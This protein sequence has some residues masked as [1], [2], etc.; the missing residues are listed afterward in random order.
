MKIL[1]LKDF[2]DYGIWGW[3]NILNHRCTIE[4]FLN[5]RISRTQ[6]IGLI[7]DLSA[8]VMIVNVGPEWYLK[9]YELEKKSFWLY[10]SQMQNNR[11]KIPKIR[12]INFSNYDIVLTS[13]PYIPEDIIKSCKTVFGYWDYINPPK[14]KQPCGGYDLQLNHLEGPDELISLPQMVFFH[15]PASPTIRA[16][17]DYI[18]KKEIYTDVRTLN[19]NPNFQISDLS[20]NNMQA[21]LP[22]RMKNGY[23]YYQL[24][25]ACKYLIYIRNGHGGSGQMAIELAALGSIIIGY[26][27]AKPFALI[28]HPFCKI[29][30]TCSE[31]KFPFGSNGYTDINYLKSIILKIE[32][33][34]LLYKEIIDYQNAVILKMFNNC[35]NI[36]EKAISIK[37]TTHGS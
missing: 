24:L 25:S 19:E 32:S 28:V 10:R 36:L 14:L 18:E 13:N 26:H 11:P 37:G 3:K 8:D 7:H 21:T 12:D 31:K 9:K 35:K 30:P 6:S 16:K 22:Q 2:R 33:D 23:K 17:F 20:I 4:D 1:L 29:N 15:Y 27:W 5:S 34:N